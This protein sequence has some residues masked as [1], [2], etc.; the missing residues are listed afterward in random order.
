M[1]GRKEERKEGKEDLLSFPCLKQNVI[2]DPDPEIAAFLS[3]IMN[4]LVEGLEF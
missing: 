3:R 1:L 4:L 2:T